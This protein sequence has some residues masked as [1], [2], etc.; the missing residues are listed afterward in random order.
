ME[1]KALTSE[2]CPRIYF[3]Y[4]QTPTHWPPQPQKVTFVSASARGRSGS[5]HDGTTICSAYAQAER[6][7]AVIDPKNFIWPYFTTYCTRPRPAGVNGIFQFLILR[8]RGRT[9]V[10]SRE[11]PANPQLAYPPASRG[12]EWNFAI[13]LLRVRGRTR[14][15]SR[16]PPAYAQLS[17]PPAS[18]G[19]ERNFTIPLSPRAGTHAG[20]VPVF[21][22]GECDSGR[23]SRRG[24]GRRT[25]A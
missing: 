15:Q 4:R 3:P 8:V 22:L 25:R 2:P 17:Y 23:V 7:R 10:Q 16:E 20:T 11:P 13:P 12:R 1:K 18:R 6:I 14:V 24:P 19:R 21:C 9:R 5:G